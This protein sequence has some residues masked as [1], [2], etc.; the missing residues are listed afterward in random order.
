VD[1][2]PAKRTRFDPWLAGVCASRVFNGLVFMSYAAALPVLQREWSMSGTQ[3]GAVAGGFQIGYA[4]SLVFFS[5]L[6]DRVSPKRIYLWSMFFAGLS[7]L[8]FALFARDFTSALVLHTTVGVS[9]GGTYTTGVMILADQYDARSRGMAVGVFI[10]STSCGYAL[11]LLISGAAL[12]AGGYRLSFL[13][14]CLGPLLGWAIAWWTLRS[15]VVP[16]ARRRKGQRFT[17]EVLAHRPTMLLIWGYVFHNWELLGMWSWTPAFLAACLAV[18]GSSPTVAAGTGASMTAL[19]HGVGLLA[20][21]SMG[22]LSDRIDRAAVMLTLA[23]VSMG[24][25]FVFGWT[26]NWPLA[27]VLCIGVVYAFSSLG[28]SPIL[29]AALTETV[30]GAYLGAALGLRSLLGFG[31]AALA[32]M[33]FGLILDWTNPA[34]ADRA[35]YAEWGWAFSALGIGGAGA[36]WAA[37]SFSQSQRRGAAG[38]LPF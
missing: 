38:N 23:G 4:M 13:L 19:F 26:V 11:S 6:A 20:S 24:C 21:F 28:D 31:A 12:P 18:A 14:T 36:V 27:W 2:T 25:S 35:F 37:R 33:V 7:A 34:A 29:S 16:A 5:S 1:G 9:L 10:A 22:A 32:P 8:G 30:D 15:T 17:R 3:A